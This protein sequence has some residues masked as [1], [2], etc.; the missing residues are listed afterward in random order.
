MQDGHG[1]QGSAAPAYFDAESV[2]IATFLGTPIAGAIL[3]AS[4]KWTAQ[5]PMG[6]VFSVLSGVIATAVLFAIGA[7]VPVLP[8][9]FTDGFTA[10]VISAVFSTVG[11]FGIGAAITLF[12]GRSVGFSGGRQVIFGLTAALLTYGIGRLIGVNL[13]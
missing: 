11:L 9:A 3:H 13:A 4:N 8:F 12:T 10:I 1:N 5:M 6:A 2:G 7:V